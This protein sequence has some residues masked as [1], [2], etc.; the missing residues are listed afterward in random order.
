MA[1]NKSGQVFAHDPDRD[2]ARMWK[3]MLVDKIGESEIRI[4]VDPHTF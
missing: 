4:T 1:G 3:A 2:G